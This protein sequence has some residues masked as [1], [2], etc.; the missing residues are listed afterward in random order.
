MKGEAVWLRVIWGMMVLVWNTMQ[1]VLVVQQREAN[2]TF[3]RNQVACD[4]LFSV[5]GHAM[6]EALAKCT[7]LWGGRLD[8][9]IALPSGC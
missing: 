5:R 3:A 4:A 6:L 1:C 2:S 8:D 9:V 7:S